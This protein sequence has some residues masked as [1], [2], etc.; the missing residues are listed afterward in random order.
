LGDIVLQIDSPDKIGLMQRL[1]YVY[2]VLAVRHT[3]A[4]RD[5]AIT[6]LFQLLVD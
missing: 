5:H 2:C 6:R 1:C 3:T 4:L